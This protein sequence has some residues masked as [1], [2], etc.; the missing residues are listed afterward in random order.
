MIGQEGRAMKQKLMFIVIGCSLALL[1]S[2]RTGAAAKLGVMCFTFTTF[3]DIL[4]FEIDDAPSGAGA[5]TLEGIQVAPAKYSI[6]VYGALTVDLIQN[7]F[8]LSW[9]FSFPETPRSIRLGPTWIRR[10]SA[11]LLSVVLASTQP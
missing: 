6:P 2:V 9:N 5:F 3:S 4:C 10:R 1:S 8:R 11:G 7:Q